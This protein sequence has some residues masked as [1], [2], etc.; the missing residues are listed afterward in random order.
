MSDNHDDTNLETPSHAESQNN[1]KIFSD[2]E[3]TSTTP[4]V[5]K[6]QTLVIAVVAGCCVLSFGGLA[7]LAHSNIQKRQDAAAQNFAKIKSSLPAGVALNHIEGSSGLFS[8]QG[9]YDLVFTKGKQSSAFQTTYTLEH[10]VASWFGG[11]VLFKGDTKLTGEA[12]KA[13]KNP[14]NIAHTEGAIEENGS[15]QFVST[16]PE[17]VLQ[18]TDKNRKNITGVEAFIKLMPSTSK[19]EYVAKSGEV[20]TNFSFPRI[21]L[22]NGKNG[23][24]NFDKSKDI[25]LQNMVVVRNFNVAQPQL[26]DFNLSIDKAGTDIISIEKVALNTG[27]ALKQNKYNIKTSLKI[28]QVKTPMG[29]ANKLELS[30]SFNGLDAASMNKFTKVY[31]EYMKNQDLDAKQTALLRE[32]FMGMASKGFVLSLDKAQGY[33]DTQKKNGAELNV[34]WEMKPSVVESE[35]S[36]SEKTKITGALTVNGPQAATANLMLNSFFGQELVARSSDKFAM[37]AE[38]DN[39]ILKVNHRANLAGLDAQINQY[40]LSADKALGLYYKKEEES[41]A[42][43]SEAVEAA[44]KAAQEAAQNDKGDKNNE[45]SATTTTTAVQPAQ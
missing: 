5:R 25:A 32:A 17:L 9:Q 38:Y 15:Y 20:K 21:E 33:M 29:Q 41:L 3:E 18:D 4:P 14:G 36:L 16:T 44:T 30:T 27:V 28:D 8:S 22:I 26:G 40:L 35:V 42:S 45:D 31:Q 6:K 19:I 11:P 24:A 2:Y 43:G 7:L 12:A 37:T 10:G 1:K 23:Q 34:Q 13:I 39:K